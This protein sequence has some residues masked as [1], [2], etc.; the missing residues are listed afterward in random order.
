M[1]TPS[2]RYVQLYLVSQKHQNQNQ[3]KLTN[4]FPRSRIISIVFLVL[5]I[6]S[7]ILNI[8]GGSI[9]SIII[10][11]LM[12]LLAVALYVG[13]QKDNVSYIFVWLIVEG[14]LLILTLIGVILIFVGLVSVSGE[15]DGELGLVWGIFVF[16]LAIVGKNEMSPVLRVDINQL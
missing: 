5:G 1:R 7:L 13:V 14:I 10:S 11:V 6:I 15:F 4:P 16:E 3:H 9:L 2:G 12:L 8:F